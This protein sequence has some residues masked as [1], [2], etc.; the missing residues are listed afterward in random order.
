VLDQNFKDKG[1]SFVSS[2]FGVFVIAILPILLLFYYYNDASQRFLDSRAFGITVFISFLLTWF[3]HRNEQRN[4]LLDSV[5][6]W[7]A[8]FGLGASI[9]LYTN[10]EVGR[11]IVGA[12]VMFYLFIIFWDW[13]R[14]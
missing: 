9:T 14:M 2:S 4:P 7:L 11:D 6:T 1:R 13:R 8:F 10:G 3:L 12:F 5:G